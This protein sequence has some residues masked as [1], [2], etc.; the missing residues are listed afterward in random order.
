MIKIFLDSGNPQDTE[1]VLAAGVHLDGQTTNPSLIAKSPAAVER[2]KAGRPFSVD[3]LDAFYRRVVT[4]VSELLP[5]GSVSIE[6]YADTTTTAEAMIK[7][8]RLVNTWIPNAHIKFP[9][10]KAGLTAA[11]AVLAEG[12]RVNMTLVFSQ[13]QAAAVYAA[14]VGAKHGDVF[15]SPFVGRLDDR[16]EQGS[17]LIANILKMYA[18]GDGHVMVLAAS[19]RT[20][21]HLNTMKELGADIATVPASLLEAKTDI[22]FMSPEPHLK[23]IPYV[24]ISLDQEWTSY[25]LHH[26]LTDQGIEKFVQDWKKLLQS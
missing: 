18:P 26:P 11:R 22:Q 14:T 1:R 16:G 5:D 2:Q 3:E 7:Q 23:P 12:M 9:T 19:I 21:A 24:A 10:T 20:A 4:E 6:V 25:D 13:A 8:A 15:L 17:D